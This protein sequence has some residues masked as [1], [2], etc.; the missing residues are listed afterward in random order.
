MI[1]TLP[2]LISGAV[3]GFAAGIS[4]GPLLTLVVSE[5]LRHNR[6]A[7]VLIAMAPILT[8]LPIVSFSFFVLAQLHESIRLLG[9]LSIS[10]G[11][12]IGHLAYE[13]LTV[14]KIALNEAPAGMKSLRRGVIANFLSPHPYLFWITVGAPTALK[15]FKISFF[16]VLLFIAGFYFFLVGSKVCVAFLVDKSRTFL[17]SNV[18]FYTIQSLGFILLLLAAFFIRDGLKML[19]FFT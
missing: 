1:E 7:G 6:K 18:Y 19:G 4:P 8:D 14:K 5:T 13:S 3:M 9:V 11:V 16:S 12:F 15:A 10:G 2:F 17:R